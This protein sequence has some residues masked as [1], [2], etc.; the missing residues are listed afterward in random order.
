MIIQRIRPSHDL[1]KEL[2]KIRIKGGIIVSGVG[3]LKNATL[4]LADEN[5]LKVKGPFE[6]ISMQ[7]TITIN[8]IHV[9]LA[10]A[11]KEGNMIGGHLKEGCEVHTTAE[12]AILPYNGILRRSK[13]EET[14][15]ME[16]QVG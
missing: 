1:K 10:I 16:L 14:G 11:D 3:S 8:G 7:G 6:I 13:D 9:H 5:I 12:I 4:R 2:L 15:Y